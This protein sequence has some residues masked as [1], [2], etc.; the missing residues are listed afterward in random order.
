M[1]FL[2]VMIASM[3]PEMLINT[4]KIEVIGSTGTL[5]RIWPTIMAIK[6]EPMVNIFRRT[7]EA[8]V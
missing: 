6:A 3:I 8:R 1:I 2:I 4:K 7:T 5:A